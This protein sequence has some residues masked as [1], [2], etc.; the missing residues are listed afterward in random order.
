MTQSLK[1]TVHS[2]NHL[3]DVESFGKND[4][5]VQVSLDYKNDHSFQKTSVKKNAGKDVEFNQELTLDGYEPT[6]NHNLYVEVFDDEHTIDAPI[7]F[8]AIPLRQVNDAPNHSFR[9]K[10]DLFTPDGKQKGT[11][12]LTL[13]AVQPGHSANHASYDG[14]EQKG[15]SQIEADHQGRIQSLKNKEKA[16]DGASLA[17]GAALAVGA[18][19]L[20]D[21]HKD[22]KKAHEAAAREH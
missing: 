1:I 20:L 7:G 12:S 8:A 6:V 21:Q 16:A 22:G 5:Y 13:S 15:Q 4:P 11:I 19:F 17:V 9:G 2:A 14:P 18:K 10:F 3:V